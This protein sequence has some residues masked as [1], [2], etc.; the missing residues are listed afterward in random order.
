MAISEERGKAFSLAQETVKQQITLSTGIFAL[1]LT[2]LKEFTTKHADKTLLEFGWGLFLLSTLL[3]VF[4]LMCLAGQLQS[5]K[6]NSE[7]TI[8]GKGIR[9]FAIGQALLFIAALALTLTFGV[10]SASV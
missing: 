1:T 3:G 8:N 7:P 4:T 10:E 5:V 9:W 2:F 6:Q